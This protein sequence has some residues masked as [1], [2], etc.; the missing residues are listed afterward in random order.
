MRQWSVVIVIA[1]AAAALGAGTACAGDGSRATMP[2]GTTPKL[3]NQLAT[4]ARAERTSGTGLATARSLGLV[5]RS[6]RVRV[7]V[8]ASGLRAAAVTAVVAVGGKVEAQHATLVQALVAPATLERLARAN[9]VR[10]VRTPQAPQLV[11]G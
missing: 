2:R 1:A 3:A 5:V 11:V 7:V 8:L 9:A 6:S 10:Y 4:V